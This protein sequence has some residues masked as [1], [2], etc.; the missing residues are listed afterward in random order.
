MS[1]TAC[2]RVL[3]IPELL[4]NIL[5]HMGDT[6]SHPEQYFKLLRVSRDFKNTIEGSPK[7]RRLMFL[8]PCKENRPYEAVEWLMARLGTYGYMA[9]DEELM[10]HHHN[11]CGVVTQRMP[12]TGISIRSLKESLARFHRVGGDRVQASWRRM[13]MSSATN[14]RPI[15]V[16][17]H[18]QMAN[19][20]VPVGPAQKMMAKW[21]FDGDQ[22]LE[23][24]FRK[25]SDLLDVIGKWTA[26]NDG[27]QRKHE[28]ENRDLL[29]DGRSQVSGHLA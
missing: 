14:S 24:L 23:D 19:R 29:A 27:M 17:F 7:V 11:G 13:K 28:Q 8:S 4:E 3:A 15:Q 26:K 16:V 2:A 22:R 25:W 9:Y 12:G 21:R 6:Y 5:L 1:T 20:T 10:E 18:I